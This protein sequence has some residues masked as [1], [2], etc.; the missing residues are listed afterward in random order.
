MPLF[1]I[2]LFVIFEIL[3][4]SYFFFGIIQRIYTL[5]AKSTK[6]WKILVD[7]VPGLTVKPWSNTR[8]ESRIKSV[9]AIRF[10]TPQI[11]SALIALEKASTDDRD[12][13]TVSECQSLVSALENFEFLVGLVIWHDI[14]FSINKVSKNCNLKL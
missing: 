14:L 5:F 10:Q 4:A 6:R 7:N 8:W 11:R 12:S 2:L 1:G 3:Q 13:M 9:Q